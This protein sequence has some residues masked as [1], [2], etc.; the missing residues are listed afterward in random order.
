MYSVTVMGPQ[1]RELRFK[2]RSKR[3]PVDSAGSDE[4]V[5]H[6]AFVENTYT[7]HPD[8]FAHTGIMI[9][10]GA[11]IGAI[12]VLACGLGAKQVIAYEPEPENFRLL[13]ENTSWNVYE[14]VLVELHPQAVWSSEGWIPLV[15]SQGASTSRLEVLEAFPSKTIPVQTV[16]LTQVL[17]PFAEVDVVKVDAE[18]AEYEMFGDLG[19]NQKI[20]VLMME[21]HPTTAT[22]FGGLLAQLSLT[23]NLQVF[24]HYNVDGGQILAKRYG[25]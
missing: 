21:Y 3:G 10:I 19:A 4:I 23:H 7:L 17:S 15:P 13:V 22:I 11:N 18:G 9:D 5:L 16:T 1:E 24:G 20:R 14:G 8:H 2:V 12:S 25:D 6:E